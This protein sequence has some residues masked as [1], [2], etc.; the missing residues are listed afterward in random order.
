MTRLLSFVFVV[1]LF[2]SCAVDKDQTK[3]NSS[4][5]VRFTLRNNTNESIPLIIPNVMNPNLSPNSDSKVTLKIGQQ[6]FF[7]NGLKRYV[8]L[9]VNNNTGNNDIVDV[10]QLIITRKKE[11]DL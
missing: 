5:K 1:S 6:I 4:E 2:A 8:L 10:A 11:L 9:E 7:K 3:A